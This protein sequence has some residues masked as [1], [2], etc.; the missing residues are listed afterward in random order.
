MTP[1]DRST[2]SRTSSPHATDRVSA[3]VQQRVIGYW[4][5]VEADL[6]ARVAAGLG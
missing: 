4:A 2:W 1:I 6:G 3:E 5:N